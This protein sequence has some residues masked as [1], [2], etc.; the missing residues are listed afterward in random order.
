MAKSDKNIVHDILRAQGVT[1]E[2]TPEAIKVFRD[3]T[4]EIWSEAT[5]DAEYDAQMAENFRQ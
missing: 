1:T 5:R 4:Q 3:A 2:P